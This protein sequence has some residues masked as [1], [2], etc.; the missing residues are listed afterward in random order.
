LFT[1]AEDAY[2]ELPEE[3]TPLDKF[4]EPDEGRVKK[5]KPMWRKSRDVLEKLEKYF[6]DKPNTR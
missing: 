3:S 4:I 5:L 6:E 2:L 1:V